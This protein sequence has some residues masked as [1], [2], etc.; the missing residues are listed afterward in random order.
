MSEK[1]GFKALIQDGTRSPV[2][3]AVVSHTTRSQPVD[4]ADHDF[5]RPRLAQQ[6][7]SFQMFAI[8]AGSGTLSVDRQGF[9][10]W[11]SDQMSQNRLSKRGGVDPMWPV[12]L[13]FS[14]LVE[15]GVVPQLCK[16]KAQGCPSELDLADF[17]AHILLSPGI[18]FSCS[19]W[20]CKPRPLDIREA[21]PVGWGCHPSPKTESCSQCV[22]GTRDSSTHA[23]PYC[24]NYS[25]STCTGR[26]DQVPR[27]PKEKNYYRMV[28]KGVRS[29]VVVTR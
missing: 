24:V 27:V 21:D 6:V 18:Q 14:H 3:R 23:G 12:M 28:G 26:P 17:P 4:R 8:S 13:P 1:E 2:L 20:F 16:S 11:V 10:V 19:V 9:V 7:M 5:D 22:A 29:I 25:L 15:S